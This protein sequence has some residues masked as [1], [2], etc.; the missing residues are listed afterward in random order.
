VGAQSHTLREALARARLT[1]FVFAEDAIGHDPQGTPF[2]S[3]IST[4]SKDIRIRP[5]VYE[6]ELWDATAGL[7][8]V[9]ALGPHE[10][11]LGALQTIERDLPGA[12]FV[13]TFPVYRA[14]RSDGS[15][16]LWAL[17]VRAAGGTKGTAIRWIAERAGVELSDTVCVGDWHNDLPMFEVA[18]RSFAMGQAPEELKSR[19]TDVLDQTFEAGGGVAR[20]VSLAFGIDAT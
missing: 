18:G 11:V 12:V 13:T 10:Q 6:H 4:W 2:V 15:S 20:A 3:Y 19:A 7:T 16:T 5:D 17:L 9:I 1:S 14:A 8:A